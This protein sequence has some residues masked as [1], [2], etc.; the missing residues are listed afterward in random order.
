M[1]IK[2]YTLHFFNK[3]TA[4]LEQTIWN[5]LN[6][7]LWKQF[8]IQNHLANS[9]IP[10]NQPHKILDVFENYTVIAPGAYYDKINHELKEDLYYP[11]YI[12]INKKK[13]YQEFEKYFAQFSNK[14]IAVHLSGGLDSSIIIGLLDHFTIPFYLV[15]LI[16]H[17][18][19]FRT[20]KYIQEILAPLGIETLLINMDDY[21]PFSNLAQKPL[22]Q[23]PDENIKQVDSG[24]AVA[25][26]CKKLGADVVFTGQG[27]DTIFVDAISSS[28]NSWSCN[29][30]NEF[31]QTYEAEILYPNEDLELISPF[32]DKEILNAIFSLRIGQKNDYLK[33]WARQFFSDILPKELVEYTYAADFFGLSMDGLEKAKP[34]IEKLFKNAYEIT[35]NKIFSPIESKDFLAIDVFNFEYQDYINYCDKISIATWYNSLLREGY[36]K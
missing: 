22:S 32:S 4:K 24:R 29:I 36:V 18:F 19:E 10:A 3:S 26:A 5:E 31:I 33:K 1:H 7:G 28:I 21:L 20:E 27:G 13:L 34:E 16:S 15:G 35:G 30:G 9:K 11:T 2:P 23:I 12:E 6:E 8:N 17:R 25:K 14:K